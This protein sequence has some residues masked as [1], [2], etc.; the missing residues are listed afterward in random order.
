MN[1]LH[2]LATL[3]TLAV[4]SFVCATS[5]DCGQTAPPPVTP[6]IPEEGNASP[7]ETASP[8]QQSP[9]A[10]DGGHRNMPEHDQACETHAPP[11]SYQ[12]RFDTECVIC[13]DGSDCGEV[14]SYDEARRRGA[15]CQREDA[16]EC[17]YAAPRCCEGRCVLSPT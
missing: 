6:S 8:P 11:T 5:C 12:C 1:E 4:L 9:E 13:H 3:A 16:A 2:P 10:P 15:A 17:E 14:M 7:Q